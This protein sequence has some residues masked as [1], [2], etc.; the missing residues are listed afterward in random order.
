L[1]SEQKQ[2]EQVSDAQTA[3]R[4]VQSSEELELGGHLPKFKDSESMLTDEDA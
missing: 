3:R 2:K 1:R 4:M